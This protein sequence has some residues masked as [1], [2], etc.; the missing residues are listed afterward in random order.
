M[1]GDESLLTQPASPVQSGLKRFFRGLY[2]VFETFVIAGG[3]VAF[4]YFFIASPHEVV[5]RSME[6]NFLDGQFLLADKVS[7]FV[8]EPK[9]GDVVI[10]QHSDTTDYIKRV[11]GLPG[12]TVSIRD[13]FIYVNSE[14]LDESKYLPPNTYTDPGPYLREGEKIKV[15]PGKYFVCGDNREHSSDSR[16]FGPIDKTTIKGRALVIYHPIRQF[17]IIERQSYTIS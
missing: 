17:T 3:F 10:F 5:G 16:T 7:Y 12:D 6:T 13:G 2:D 14:K 15:P 8:S 1:Y 4:I 9:R 11:I